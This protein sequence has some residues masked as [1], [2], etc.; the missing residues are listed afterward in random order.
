MGEAFTMSL[1]LGDIKAFTTRNK[2]KIKEAVRPAAQA[3]AQVLYDATKPTLA[4]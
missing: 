2:E 1:N 4:E 3:G